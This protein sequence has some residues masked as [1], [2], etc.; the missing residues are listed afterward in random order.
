QEL[1][2]KESPRTKF[3]R[4]I[5]V[6]GFSLVTFQLAKDGPGWVLN[7]TYNLEIGRYPA[8]TIAWEQFGPCIRDGLLPTM[9]PEGCSVH[10]FS[11]SGLI[12]TFHVTVKS[13]LVYSVVLK[14]V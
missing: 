2:A 7:C 12:I 14:R 3:F 9:G 13:Q 5:D 8:A 1:T 6:G 4:A 10:E 11:H